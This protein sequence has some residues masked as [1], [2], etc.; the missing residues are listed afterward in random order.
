MKIKW[1]RLTEPEDL[2]AARQAS[3]EAGERLEEAQRRWPIV[4]RQAEWARRRRDENHLT[5]LFW[6]ERPRKA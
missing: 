1:P 4:H 6:S 5:E 2:R 3:E